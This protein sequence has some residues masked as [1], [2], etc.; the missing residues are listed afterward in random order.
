MWHSP[1]THH[2][3][4]TEMQW[5]RL[6]WHSILHLQQWCLPMCLQNRWKCTF[7]L[8]FG[9][10]NRWLLWYSEGTFFDKHKHLHLL[11]TIPCLL[12]SLESKK[13]IASNRNKTPYPIQVIPAWNVTL[14]LQQQPSLLWNAV[15]V[16][17]LALNIALPTMVSFNVS[18]K[19]VKGPLGF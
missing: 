10:D 11:Q 19:Q 7:T 5:L 15:I 13:K 9:G 3:C 1:C 6:N 12:L 14:L 17:Q 16:F 8:Q 2:C 18:A 4:S